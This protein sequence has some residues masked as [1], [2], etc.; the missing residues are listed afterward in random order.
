M[1]TTER[2]APSRGPDA[3]VRDAWARISL[4]A[5]DIGGFALSPHEL[6]ALLRQDP[7]CADPLALA[8]ALIAGHWLVWLVGVRPDGLGDTFEPVAPR[9]RH[10]YMAQ[11]GPAHAEASAFAARFAALPRK[12]GAP[13]PPPVVTDEVHAVAAA[14]RARVGA[15][16]VATLDDVCAVH[17]DHAPAV[18]FDRLVT[19]LE[20]L[21]ALRSD[22]GRLTVM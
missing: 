18:P 3:L 14:L 4:H 16:R 1:T 20:S 6:G 9:E 17:E 19:M 15:G 10:A 5:A 12:P 11:H 7:D 2:T 13:P 22:A 8:A 21:G